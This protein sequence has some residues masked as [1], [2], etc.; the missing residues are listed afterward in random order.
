MALRNAKGLNRFVYISCAP[1]SATRNWID[2]ARPCSK[3]YK[4][5]VI[6]I[7]FFFLVYMDIILGNP[8]VPKIAV[9]VDM[10]PHTYHKEMVVLFERVKDDEPNV[11]AAESM[12]PEIAIPL[13][14]TIED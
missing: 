14:E 4:G 8:F 3:S 13:A 1:K 2:L 12:E 9:G 5:S 7:V 6:L 10:F 11:I